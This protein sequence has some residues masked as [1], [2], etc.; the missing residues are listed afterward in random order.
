MNKRQDGGRFERSRASNI[1]NQLHLGRAIK[2]RGGDVEPPVAD[3]RHAFGKGQQAVGLG[4]PRR[5]VGGGQLDPSTGIDVVHRHDEFARFARYRIDRR[6]GTG[7]DPEAAA[8][9]TVV[10]KLRGGFD[11]P[12]LHDG[13]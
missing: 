3:V 11:R 2:A 4:Q 7:L 13:E 1:E 12:A 8:S 6:T 9:A 10:A 5:C